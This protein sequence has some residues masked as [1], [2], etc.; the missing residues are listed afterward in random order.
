MTGVSVA[1]LKVMI[2][3]C[4]VLPCRCV[5]AGSINGTN[6][7]APNQ[8]ASPCVPLRLWYAFWHTRFRDQGHED[9]GS[10]TAVA[11]SLL[12]VWATDSDGGHCDSRVKDGRSSTVM[13]IP[14]AKS[15]TGAESLAPG[16]R[17]HAANT[18][19]N[20]AI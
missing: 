2:W 4:I 3:F 5:K 13:P 1:L 15:V 12:Y 7:A 14:L 10:G 17:I 11:Q 6:N 18:D 8:S 20:H 9:A 19:Q 16:R